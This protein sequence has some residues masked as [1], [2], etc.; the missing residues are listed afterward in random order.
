[1]SN[2]N[3]NR[4]LNWLLEE[5]QPSVRHY[6]L[7]ELLGRDANDEEVRKAVSQIPKKGWAHDILGLQK[8]SGNWESRRSLYRPKYTATNWRALVLSDLGLK[9]DDP[10]IRKMVKLF[11]DEWLVLPSMRNIFNDEVCIVGNTA[12]MLTRFGYEDDHRVRKL[13]DRLIEDQKED[14]GW[15]CFESKTGTLDGW[16]GLAAFAS[17]PKSKRSRRVQASIERGAEFYL[18]KRLFLEGKD[19]YAP[20]FRLHY[21]NHYYYDVLV[22]LD[23]IT[24]LGFS[25]DKRLHPA[26]EM[27]RKKRQANGTWVIERIHPDLG[28]HADYDLKGKI[29]PFELEKSG[30]QS[31]WITLT[32]LRV[33]K[34]IEDA[35]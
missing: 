28:A 9:A 33:L 23:M 14:G 3:E 2:Q 17:L 22:G 20:W 16:E 6:A 18:G 7:T 34:R 1:M 11:F 10:R 13:F 30:K 27:L 12:R 35:S 26:L 31:K 8:P 21:P 24:K 5:D 25:R 29:K 4:V 19:K 15:H 32:A